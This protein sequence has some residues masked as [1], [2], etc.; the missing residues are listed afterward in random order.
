MIPYLRG[1][2][3]A[4]LAQMMVTS[5][6]HVR[7]YSQY[8]EINKAAFGK[9]IEIILIWGNKLTGS[10][11]HLASDSVRWYDPKLQ[12]NQIIPAEIVKQIQVVNHELGLFDGFQLGFLG[13]VGITGFMAL[14]G[15]GHPVFNHLNSDELVLFGLGSG[16]LYGA[17]ISVP[18]SI[19]GSRDIY[20]ISR[21]NTHI[22]LN[23][24]NG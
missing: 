14:T 13:G 20:Y 9:E 11:L 17:L 24:D 23:L 7:E 5:C 10:S 2:I 16:L 22:K 3:L 8:D 18:G 15:E 4:L 21:N 19:K 12:S 6:S 1:L